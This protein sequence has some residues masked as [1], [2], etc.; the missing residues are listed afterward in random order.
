MPTARVDEHNHVVKIQAVGR[1][2]IDSID[3]GK[4]GLL[5]QYYQNTTRHILSCMS[6]LEQ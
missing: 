6:R 5:H 2:Y 3:L 4:C 1:Q